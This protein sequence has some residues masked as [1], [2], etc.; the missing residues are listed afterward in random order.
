MT[1]LV[2]T[3]HGAAQQLDGRAAT[4]TLVIRPALDPPVIRQAGNLVAS[5]PLVLDL[6][7]RGDLGAWE[8]EVPPNDDPTLTN[9]GVPYVV[10]EQLDHQSPREWR[11]FVVEVAPAG[12]SVDTSSIEGG[13]VTL[14][15]GTAGRVPAVTT[16]GRPANPGRAAVHYFDT[17][18]GQPIWWNGV[19]W[20]DAAGAPA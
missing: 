7:D 4:G 17:T 16:A 15:V 10:T 14:A 6:V 3:L 1:F 20:V 11:S 2:C 12:G 9:F 8:V 5:G 19:A 13:V 18:L